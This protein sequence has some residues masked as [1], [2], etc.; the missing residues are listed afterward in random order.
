MPSAG[1]PCESDPGSSAAQI[2]FSYAV[3]WSGNLYGGGPRTSILEGSSFGLLLI[4]I[5]AV[6]HA[7]SVLGTRADPLTRRPPPAARPPR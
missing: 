5:V 7:A 4:D 6:R 2:F 1:P 3:L